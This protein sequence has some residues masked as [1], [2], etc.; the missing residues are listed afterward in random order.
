MS[1]QE[2]DLKTYRFQAG[3]HIKVYYRANFENPLPF[4]HHGIFIGY[5]EN[6]EP[7]IINQSRKGVCIDDLEHFTS[8]NNRLWIVEHDYKK[9]SREQVVQRALDIYNDKENIDKKYDLIFNN[10]EHF[11]NFIIEGKKESVQVKN[12]VK[13]LLA[14]TVFVASSALSTYL[15][16]KKKNKTK[17]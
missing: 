15:A 14:G 12:T 6:N 3:D 7:Q 1:S 13:T 17:I 8:G 11:A 5:N 4:Y 9:F 10:C 16:V 2:I